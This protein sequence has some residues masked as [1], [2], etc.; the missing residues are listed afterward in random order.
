MAV[1]RR[2]EM[3]R[4]DGLE[5]TLDQAAFRHLTDAWRAYLERLF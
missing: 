1:L 5:R 3:S 2:A 4:I